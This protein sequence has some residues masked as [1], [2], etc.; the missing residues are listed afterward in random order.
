MRIVVGVEHLV[1]I[2]PPMACAVYSLDKFKGEDLS[3]ASATVVYLKLKRDALK[4]AGHAVKGGY[5]LVA[6]FHMF[7]LFRFV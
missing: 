6:N 3:L 4:A 2:I 7:I 5:N 1:A